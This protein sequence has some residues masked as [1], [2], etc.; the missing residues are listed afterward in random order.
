MK[1]LTQ[2]NLNLNVKIAL[3]V[4]SVLKQPPNCT[5]VLKVPLQ[6]R[7]ILKVWKIALN[8]LQEKLVRLPEQAHQ[9]TVGLETTV[10][11]GLL[12]LFNAKQAICAT[13]PLW[14]TMICLLVLV[15][16]GFCVLQILVTLLEK[17]VVQA[18][19]V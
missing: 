13:Q 9:P 2:L 5:R 15:Q 11:K 1:Q 18:I 12:M 3:L 19:T 7:L 10:M 8:V 14:I 17:N 16:L 4:I 6:G